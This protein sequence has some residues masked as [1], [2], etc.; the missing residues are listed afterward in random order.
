MITAA[1]IITFVALVLAWDRP[2]KPSQPRTGIWGQLDRL[3]RIEALKEQRGE[4]DSQIAALWAEY[5]REEMKR[6]G[7][8]C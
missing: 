5:E 7:I 4:N 8:Q 2:N 1:I 3:D 6:D